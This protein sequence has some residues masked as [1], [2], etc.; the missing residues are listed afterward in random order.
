MRFATATELEDEPRH[1]PGVAVDPAPRLP[2]AAP[3]ASSEQGL[4][5]LSTPPDVGQGREVVQRFFRAALEE[6]PDQLQ[7]LMSQDA[8]ASSSAGGSRQR[9]MAFWRNRLRRLDYGALSGQL[10]YRD[11]EIE[12]YRAE[13]IPE[14]RLA[15]RPPLSARGSELVVRVPIAAPRLGRVR[16]FG[17]EI[18][19]L[20]R[21][22]LDG[23]TIVEMIED[24]RLP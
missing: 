11:S 9:A 7:A 16:L 6:A 24:F 18:W 14:L 17:D 8:Y 1:P 12:T 20:L 15:R 22:Q 23:Y 21:P 13:D 3:E 10:V 4:V 2:R 5:V 19:F